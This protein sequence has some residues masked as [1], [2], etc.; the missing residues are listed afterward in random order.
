M[1]EIEQMA[2]ILTRIHARADR[3]EGEELRQFGFAL[4]AI[5]GAIY[6]QAKGVDPTVSM[7]I[8]MADCA[9]GAHAEGLAEAVVDGWEE[10]E[11]L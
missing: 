11:D 10:W 9:G 4:V 6:S 1:S 2:D 8:G 5:G 7:F 3:L